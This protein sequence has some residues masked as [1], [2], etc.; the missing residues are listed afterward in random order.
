M[1]VRLLLLKACPNFALLLSAAM[2]AAVMHE[3]IVFT[4]GAWDHSARGLYS[5]TI[6]AEA[7]SVSTITG[8]ALPHYV[9][10][11]STTTTGI[12]ADDSSNSRPTT[13][14]EDDEQYSDSDYD[15][16]Y[17]KNTSSHDSNLSRRSGAPTTL[18]QCLEAANVTIYDSSSPEYESARQTLSLLFTGT[19]PVAIVYPESTEQVAASVRCARVHN[20]RFH[21]RCGNHNTEGQVC[22]CVYVYVY[23]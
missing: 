2:L 14:K 11:T 21:P 1:A 13:T 5:P 17:Y 15:D 6:F 9:H 12:G 18:I 19:W 22:V 8:Y 23:V 3:S 7:A 20:I 16:Y 10:V 4:T